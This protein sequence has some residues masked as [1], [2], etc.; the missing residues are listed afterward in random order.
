MARE[1][2]LSV[3]T[4]LIGDRARSQIQL[5][6]FPVLQSVLWLTLLLDDYY[7]L[8]MSFLYFL[9]FLLYLVLF[10]CQSGYT[11]NKPQEEQ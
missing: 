3:I 1:C 8:L 5:F 11:G 4:E 7:F 6:G 2:D 9:G 10:V